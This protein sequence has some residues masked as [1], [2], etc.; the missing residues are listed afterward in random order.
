MTQTDDG[1]WL[2]LCN[3]GSGH[4]VELI[5]FPYAGGGTSVFHGWP[6]R[7]TPDIAVRMV[8]LPGRESRYTEPPVVKTSAVID[9]V[10][11]AVASLGD[12]P[13]VLF[14]HSMG[15]ILAF[16]V[17]RRLQRSARPPAALIVSGRCAP[18]LE[19]R[20]PQLADLRGRELVRRLAE[21]YGGI[22]A[23]VLDDDELIDVM[24]RVLEADLRL[25]ESYA[26]ASGDLLRCP[27]ATYGGDGDSWVSSVEL[28]AWGELTQAGFVTQQYPGDHFYFRS[29]ESE[30]RLLDSIRQIC[31]GAAS[32]RNGLW[33]ATPD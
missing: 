14:G 33:T 27:I 6:R 23:E 10:S 29:P 25:V 8:Q 12:L 13:V 1:E 7:L 9:P 4:R 3:A 2:R 18:Q 17:V 24:T 32:G 15:A 26:Y 16:E 30:R 11:R 31:A 28:E 21:H 20:S 22:P 5:V 19:S